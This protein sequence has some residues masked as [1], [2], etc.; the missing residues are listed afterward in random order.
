MTRQR[1]IAGQPY[2]LSASTF[3][4]LVNDLEARESAK[5][6]FDEPSGQIPA[7]MQVLAKNVSGA[8]IARFDVL[9]LT[10]VAITPTAN[11]L[12][13][14]NRPVFE[15]DAPST[16]ANE[17]WGVALAP[18]AVGAVIPIAIGGIV[19][20][21][22]SVA[23]AAH[24][25]AHLKASDKSQLESNF[26]G[27]ARIWWKESGTGTKWALCELG[28]QP[29]RYV[30]GVTDEAIAVDASGYVSVWLN[31]ADSTANIVAELSWMHGSQAISL[32]KEVKAEWY[33]DARKW[34]ITNA[35]CE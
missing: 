3:N 16:A 5:R 18:A 4:A 19:P 15:C 17:R 32:G 10:G 20:V 27:D 24:D 1:L 29:D 23:H 2:Q 26:G 22:V 12:S 6:S 25:R 21:R 28:I 34:V 13:F 7:R 14:Q 31:G 33:H 8:A 30:L 35:D 9:R 11:L